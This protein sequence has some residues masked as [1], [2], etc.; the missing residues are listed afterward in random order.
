MGEKEEIEKEKEEKDGEWM[1]E[2]KIS[3]GYKME[4]KTI[5]DVVEKRFNTPST[6]NLIFLL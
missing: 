1:R 6:P 3:K 4:I 5:L 2:I